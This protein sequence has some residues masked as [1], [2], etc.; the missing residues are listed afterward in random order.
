MFTWWRVAARELAAVQES[1]FGGVGHACEF[2]TSLLQHFASQLVVTDQIRPATIQPTFEWAE[3]DMLNAPCGM[4][5]RSMK[6]MS[7]GSGVVGQ[8]T[9]AS[10]DKGRRISD[11]VVSKLVGMLTDIRKTPASRADAAP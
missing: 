7:G 9:Y 2:E 4:L 1:G 3:A 5:Y 11:T 8:P 6:E 10:A